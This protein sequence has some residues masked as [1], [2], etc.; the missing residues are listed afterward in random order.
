[1][2]DIDHR[3]QIRMDEATWDRA[4]RAAAANGIVRLSKLYEHLLERE[5]ARLGIGQQERA[6]E[7]VDAED[8]EHRLQVRVK[9]GLWARAKAMA[10]AQGFDALSDVCRNLLE[11]AVVEFERQQ[12]LASKTRRKVRRPRLNE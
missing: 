1:M 2:R 10:A 11:A 6:A 8:A 9:H 12:E 5:C 4:Q 3:V 7:A